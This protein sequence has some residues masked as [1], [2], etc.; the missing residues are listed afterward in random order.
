MRKLMNR[1]VLSQCV[2]MA[3]T[4]FAA[5]A[6][7][8]PATSC[9]NGVTTQTCGLSKD[10]DGSFYQNTGIA[11]AVMA[12]ATGTNIFMDGHRQSGDTQS[13]TVSGTDMS[14]YYIQGSNGG[15]VNITLN[16]GATADMIEVGNIGATTDTTVTLNN[17]TLNGE[18]DAGHYEGNKAYMMGSAIYLDPMDKGLHTVNI[19]NGSALHG[20]IVSAGAGA[21]NIAISNSTMDKGGIYAGSDKSDTTITLTNATVNASQSE[22]SQNIDALAV[23]L[24][25]YTPFSDINL[26]AF[27]DVA[28]A[29]YGKTADSLALN[30]S[31]LTGDIGVINENG[32]ANITVQNNSVVNGNVTVDGNSANSI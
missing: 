8:T 15:A 19:E 6:A 3:L 26:D 20:S 1:T 30:N 12:D 18:N 17:A 14:G 25:Q 9:Q 11:N 23:K 7:V 16:N 21:Q 5:Q 31:T 13:L 4:S 29:M 10:T 22:I 24:S 2:L 32:A 27:G 28:V